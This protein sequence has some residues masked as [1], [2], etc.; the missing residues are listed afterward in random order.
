LLI[1]FD[2]LAQ[3][4]LDGTTWESRAGLEQR[5]AALLPGLLLA[6]VDG[7][8]PVEYLTEEAQRERV[9]RVAGALLRR[10][11]RRLEDVRVAWQKEL[12]R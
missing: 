11:V 12:A 10:T 9:R 7:K 2:V 6:R 8:S 1:C 5:A 4:Y 3:A